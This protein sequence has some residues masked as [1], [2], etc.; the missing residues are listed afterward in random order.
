[1]PSTTPAITILYINGGY[2]WV[3]A[4]GD[5]LDINGAIEMTDGVVLVNGPTE[6]MN[7]ALDYDG[8]FNI[9]GGFLVAVG[10]A[11]MAQAPR[12]ISS[13][14]SLL[15][16]LS[17][18]TAAGT[19]IHIQNSAG[20]DILTFAPTKHYQSIAFS[21]PELVNG[22]T[23][24]ISYGGSSSGSLLGRSIPGRQLQ[25]RDADYQLCRIR[26]GNDDRRWWRQDAA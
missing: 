21:S 7:G 8:G 22:E 4:D 18:T 9:S 15:I 24:T 5:G 3:D 25:L 20:E 12:Q 14:N 6:N 10:S 11:G 13:Q 23:Y 2:I 17:C 19:L 1:M 26:G 16:N